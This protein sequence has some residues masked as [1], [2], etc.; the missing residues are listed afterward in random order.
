M[1]AAPK[2][3]AGTVDKAPIKLPIGVRA[4]ATITTFLFMFVGFVLGSHFGREFN[5]FKLHPNGFGVKTK[6]ITL[7][8]EIND[9]RKK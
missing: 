2:S 5:Q 4:A 7:F 8:F 1:A 9:C 6:A 3:G